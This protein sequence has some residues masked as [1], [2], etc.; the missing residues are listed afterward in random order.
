MSGARPRHRLGW[1]VAAVALAAVTGCGEAERRVAA[2]GPIPTSTPQTFPAADGRVLGALEE[3]VPEGP[4]LVP[5]VSV[6]EPGTNRLAF[7]LADG[8]GQ[9]LTG[10]EVALYV[11]RPH[12]GGLVGPLAART[13]RLAGGRSVYVVDLAFSDAGEWMLVA[14]ARLDGR[15]V[16]TPTTPVRVRTLRDGPPRVGDR[17]PRAEVPADASAARGSVPI[18]L[19]RGISRDAV[20]RGPL[21]LVFEPQ[22]GCRTGACASP[23][24]AA[25]AVAPRGRVRVV[26][27]DEAAGRRAA[28]RARRRYRLP[29]LPWVFVVDGEGIVR[30][31]FEGPVSARELRRA[32]AALDGG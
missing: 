7:A 16:R 25:R 20:G 21:V 3:G 32:V 1:A 2:L 28:D 12:G 9:R 10:A 11:A 15:L 18:S 6:L 22:G 14:V 4:T 17:A 29:S 31:R 26:V 27:V 5:A 8:A 23:E 30:E 24:D 13:E 19:A